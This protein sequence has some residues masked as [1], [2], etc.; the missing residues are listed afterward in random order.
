MAAEFTVMSD[1]DVLKA[2][3]V[4]Y[5][6]WNIFTFVMMGVDK[7]KA[8]MGSWRISEN[9]LLC[10]AFVFGG[11]GALLGS[12]VFRHKTQKLKFRVLLPLSVAVNWILIFVIWKFGFGMGIGF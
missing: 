9:T 6:I 7:Q 10:A 1:F 12:W 8:K 4:M 3:M 5:G 2:V 11:L